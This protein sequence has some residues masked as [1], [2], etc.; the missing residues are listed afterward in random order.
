MLAKLGIRGSFGALDNRMLFIFWKS[1]KYKD[2]LNV[3]N[4]Y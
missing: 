2:L 1:K 3:I 4:I